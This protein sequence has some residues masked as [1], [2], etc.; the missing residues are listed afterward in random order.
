MSVAK[1]ER[2]AQ[3]FLDTIKG[4]Q[5]EYPIYMDL[6]VTEQFA[7]G[8]ATCSAMVDAF[9][10]KLKIDKNLQNSTLTSN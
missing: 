7:L 3:V 4:K 6:E 10:T 5:F 9:L 2:E 1:A 8:K